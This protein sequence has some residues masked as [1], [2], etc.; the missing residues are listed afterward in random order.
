M[1]TR[2]DELKRLRELR[3]L[4]FKATWTETLIRAEQDREAD[5]YFEARERAL[6]RGRP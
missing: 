6:G 1:T 3:E 2:K 5:A 4:V